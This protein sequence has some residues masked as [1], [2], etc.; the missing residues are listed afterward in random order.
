M[1]KNNFSFDK[2]SPYVVAVL[3]FII[4]SFAYFSPVLDGKVIMGHDTQ[5]YLGMSKEATDVEEATGEQQFWT[6]SMFGGMPTY[7]ITGNY[8]PGLF[9]YLHK[10]LTVFPRPASFLF[11]FLVCGFLL[12]LSFG[13]KPWLSMVGSILFAFASYNFIIIAVGHST[14]AIVM[15]YVLPL[16]GSVAL[17]YR[18]KIWLGGLL[19]AIFLGMA[20]LAN[21]LQILYYTLFILIILFVVELIYA[22]IE[23]KISC[24]LKA[25]G[26]LMAAAL[27]AI[28]ANAPSLLATYEYSRHTMRGDS[29]GLTIDKGSEQ[30][31]LNTDYITM[32]SYGIDETMTL[33]IPNF[34]GSSSA[35]F[36]EEGSQ[37]LQ[38]LQNM[39]DPEAANFIYRYTSFYWGTQPG[40]SG[41][42]YVGAT[43]CLLFVLGLCIVKGR[44]KWWL[45]SATI[46]SFLLAWGHNFMPFTQFFIDYVPLYNKFRAV[47]M[48]LVMAGISMPLLAM[49]AVKTVFDETVDKNKIKTSLLISTGI[50]GGICLLCWLFPSLAGSFTAPGNENLPPA[51]L[52]A[53]RADRMEMLSNDA[54]RSLVFVLLTAAV[55]YAVIKYNM[56]M[57]Y[58]V[59]ALGLLFLFDLSPI[60]KRYLNESNFIE[61]EKTITPFKASAADN[62]ILQ[63][64]SHF[65]T[66]DLTKNIFNDASSAYFHNDVG[67]YHAA[68]LRRYQELINIYLDKEIAALRQV[69]TMEEMLEQLKKSSILNMLNMK[70]IILSPDAA[71]IIN[72]FANGNAWLVDKIEI[73]DS[74]DEEMTVLGSID[75]KKEMVFDQKDMKSNFSAITPDSTASISLT[76]YEPMRLVYHFNGATNQMAVFSEI[77]YKNGW[78]VYINGKKATYFRANYL[79]RAM[80]LSAGEYDIE[81]R[82]EPQLI[83]I[84]DIIAITASLLILLCVGLLV[85]KKHKGWKK[86]NLE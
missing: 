38:A 18:G 43:V 29:N 49:L 76:N 22:A 80:P 69:R 65:R 60:A 50:I 6:D 46:L 37:T 9:K 56:K 31:G 13:I 58:A 45:L 19:T 74:A 28:A 53:L 17:A 78:N 59:T 73:A 27:I 77:Y 63:D 54:F 35:E 32:W 57:A 42:V 8:G 20:I 14:K 72:P 34:N 10:A 79:L 64:T 12:L 67:G 4:L 11:L 48:T 70:Y 5:S 44:Y 26:V 86:S 7:Q 84:G 52:S 33:L 85:W 16:I 25:T 81:F 71:P 36:P 47:S 21:H 30:Q 24:F 61:K 1:Q 75:T 2:V 3:L 23:K 41:P 83:R 40:T 55:L 51:I 15:A 82:F 66:L 62:F 68:K 39:N